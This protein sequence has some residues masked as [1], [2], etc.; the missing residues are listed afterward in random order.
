M[1]TLHLILLP[2]ALVLIVAS[3][4]LLVRKH[5]VVPPYVAKARAEPERGRT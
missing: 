5:G 1:Y 2:V 4:V 3:H